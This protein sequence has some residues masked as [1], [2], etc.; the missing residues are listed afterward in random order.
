MKKKLLAG[1][2]AVLM[3]FGMTGAVCAGTIFPDNIED[4]AT[5]LNR[6]NFISWSIL[7][8]PAHDPAALL[9][10]GTGLVGLIDARR[11]KNA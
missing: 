7:A 6:G 4:E 2:I 8:D 11:K 1:L 9:L 5:G 3:L 10:M